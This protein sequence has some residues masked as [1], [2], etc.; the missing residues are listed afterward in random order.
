MNNIAN[1]HHQVRVGSRAAHHQHGVATGKLCD[2]KE[3]GWPRAF[4]KCLIFPILHNPHDFSRGSVHTLAEVFANGI[5]RANHSFCERH[6]HDGDRRV[7]LPM[8]VAPGQ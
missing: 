5:R 7:I 3:Y 8:N 2:R 6:I 1:R 4:R